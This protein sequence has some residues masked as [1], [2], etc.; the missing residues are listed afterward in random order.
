MKINPSCSLVC[1]ILAE[2]PS[3][4]E[5]VADLLTKDVINTIDADKIQSFKRE[6]LNEVYL[7]DH[8]ISAIRAVNN[9]ILL[10]PDMFLEAF[11]EVKT[12]TDDEGKPYVSL[13]EKKK[14]V[15]GVRN[16]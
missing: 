4:R 12:D 9:I 6:V 3:F 8:K 1:A 13:S 16:F 14:F 15:E 11:P 7:A 2:S 10:N 5:H